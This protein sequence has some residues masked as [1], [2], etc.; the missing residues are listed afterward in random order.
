MCVCVCVCVR[1]WC[2]CVC[3]CERVSV[4]HTVKFYR[5]KVLNKYRKTFIYITT[6][7]YC[8][9]GDTIVIFMGIEIRITLEIRL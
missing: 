5:G 3:V 2:V 9:F 6:L 8:L 7:V 1:V 4:P